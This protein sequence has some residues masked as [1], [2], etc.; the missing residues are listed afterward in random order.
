MLPQHY[1]S[2]VAP[3]SKRA[4][5]SRRGTVHVALFSTRESRI[6]RFGGFPTWN[7]PEP[8]WNRPIP[9]VSTHLAGWNRRGTVWN[10]RGTVQFLV[11]LNISPAGTVVEP[12]GTVL[13]P[14]S[15][16]CFSTREPRTPFA[17]YNFI[18]KNGESASARF[19]RILIGGPGE[20]PTLSYILFV[21]PLPPHF[22]V[23][24]R[25]VVLACDSA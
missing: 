11:F 5:R 25:E 17:F 9:C 8:S 7:R 1:E 12:S 21:Q 24:S 4:V 22:F 10:R 14:S 20:Q 13:E 23:W 18:K 19:S 2:L 3:P 6:P 15:L 16:L